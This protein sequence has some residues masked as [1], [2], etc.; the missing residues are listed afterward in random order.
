MPSINYLY[1]AL[2]VPASILVPIGTAM[3]RFKNLGKE[4]KILFYYTLLNGGINILA[5]ILWYLKIKNL[6]VLHV[7]TILEFLVI[8]QMYYHM[9]NDKIIKMIIKYL[10]I[11]FPILCIANFIFLQ[12]IFQFNTNTRP[13]EALL[14]MM[15]SLAYFAQINDP[16]D[17]KMWGEVPMNWVS[18]ALLIYFSGALFIF[19][20][21][22]YT[23]I[24]KNPKFQS[25][26]VLIWNIHATLVLIMYLLFAKGF[27]KCRKA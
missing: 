7:F 10:M 20:F 17:G 24:L 14:I 8:A 11:I 9:L 2:I 5:I 15:F 18:A 22:N 3:Y 6:P 23:S 4:M 25:L 21:S 12:S 26:N 19:S 16:T 13:F 1:I 27:S